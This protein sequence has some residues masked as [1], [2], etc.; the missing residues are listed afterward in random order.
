MSL[1]PENLLA[2]NLANIP[3][4]ALVNID[5]LPTSPSSLSSLGAHFGL[6]DHNRLLPAFG[7]GKVDAIIDHHDD[8]RAHLDAS[9]RVVTVPT[10]SCSSLITQH[11]MPQ[12]QATQPQIE[13]SAILSELASL[14]LSAILI[15]TAGLKTGGKATAVDFGSAAFLYPL[16]SLFEGDSGSFTGTALAG[17]TPP[18]LARTYDQLSAAK[19]DVDGL[20]THDLLL[21][22]YKEYESSTASSSY[23]TLRAG[24]STVPLGL[25]KWLA[26]E[27][28]GWGSYLSSVDEYM[29]ERNLDIEG[30]LTTFHSDKG[31]HK[32]ELA[33]FVRATGVLGTPVEAKRVMDELTV[34]MEA[35]GDVLDLSD[36]T[37][38]K[39]GERVSVDDES[40]GRFGTVWKQGNTKSTR[41][42]V[43]PLLVRLAQAARNT[44]GLTA[45]ARSSSKIVIGGI[46]MPG[47][48]YTTWTSPF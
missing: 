25:N 13:N 11:F 9:I 19:F 37:A 31:K 20:S 14:L 40:K 24:L 33:L 1:R 22:D 29:S 39:G 36:W 28:D 45:P 2:L 5:Q 34:G 38:T 4:S 48:V 42:Q 15:D 8:E 3:P 44:T 12:W 17:G 16:S 27:N 21:R 10:G 43:A 46:D 18:T 30:V 6:V 41:K 35:N 47:I 32:R 23:P 26:K 7:N